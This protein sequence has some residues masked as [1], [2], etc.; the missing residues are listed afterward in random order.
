MN[1]ILDTFTSVNE[2]EQLRYPSND[3]S[4]DFMP[5]EMERLNLANGI[6]NMNLYKDQAWIRLKHY[7]V[8]SEGFMFSDLSDPILNEVKANMIEEMGH[9]GSSFAWTMRQLQYIAK[10]GFLKYVYT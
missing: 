10:Y 5:G 3:D 6:K 7:V 8:S 9:T 4:L 2:T 1:Q